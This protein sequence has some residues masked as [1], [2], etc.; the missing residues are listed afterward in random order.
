MDSNV[1]EGQ[2]LMSLDFG[3][4]GLQQCRRPV[5]ADADSCA[6]DVLAHRRGRLAR[7]GDHRQSAAVVGGTYREKPSFWL[8][9]A[10]E[11]DSP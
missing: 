11:R 10:V 4:R 1:D 7:V 2:Y 3:I 6:G 8:P 5:A 9:V